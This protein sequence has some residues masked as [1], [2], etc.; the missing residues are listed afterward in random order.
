MYRCADTGGG[1]IGT[2]WRRWQATRNHR[3]SRLIARDTGTDRALRGPASA[4]VSP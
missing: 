2:A 1:A 3:A 4:V